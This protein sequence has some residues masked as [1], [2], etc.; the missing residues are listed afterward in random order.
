MPIDRQVEELLHER[1]IDVCHETVRYWW[2]RFG[3]LFAAE[4]K[5]TRGFQNSDYSPTPRSIDFSCGI[6]SPSA[7]P[8]ELPFLRA[9]S[10]SILLASQ[11]SGAFALLHFRRSAADNTQCLPVIARRSR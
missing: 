4:I 5:N 8:A 3:S 9:V 11:S 1:G 6:F 7:V 2:N 10:A